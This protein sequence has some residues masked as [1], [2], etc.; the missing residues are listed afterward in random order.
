GPSGWT[1]GRPAGMV[2]GSVTAY[3]GSFLVRRNGMT[4]WRSVLVLPVLALAA[5]GLA[6]AEP[7]PL[8]SAHGT[9]EKGGQDALSVLPRLPD[10]TF[11]KRL[12]LRVTGTSK[13]ATLMPRAEKG[14]VVMTQ[15]ESDPKDLQP[16]QGVAVLYTL[17]SD[18]PILLT[19]VVQPPN[20]G[21]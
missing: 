9:V 12:V 17:V 8:L 6:A 21:K 19:A 14:R 10:G 5:G 2:A 3:R 13:V 15:R 18:T 20:P 7:P 1:G 11:G 4:R 16:K